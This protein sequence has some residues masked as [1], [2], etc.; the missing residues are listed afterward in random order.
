MVVEQE[1]RIYGVFI[2]IN[3][4]AC[5]TLPL[6]LHRMNTLGDSKF[7]FLWFLHKTIPLSNKTFN[8]LDEETGKS[9]ARVTNLEVHPV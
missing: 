6:S 9:K 1:V 4:E 7:V 2:G 8:P 5:I 3:T